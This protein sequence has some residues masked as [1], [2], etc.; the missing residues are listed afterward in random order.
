VTFFSSEVC[1]INQAE[2]HVEGFHARIRKDSRIIDEMQK[3]A[4]GLYRIGL[5]DKKIMRKREV[6]Q[7]LEGGEMVPEE[8]RPIR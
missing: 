8:T 1:L 4:Q 5:I 7:N 2:E 3:T 6:F